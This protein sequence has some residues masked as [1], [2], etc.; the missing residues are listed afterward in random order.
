MG[1]YEK[2]LQDVLSGKKDGN[3]NFNELC[4]LLEKLG[5]KQER[6]TGS[7]HIFSYKNVAELVDIQP[8]KRDHSKAKAYQVKQ[9]KKF[10]IKYIEVL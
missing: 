9:V 1:K 3:I 10:I 4:Y 8:D 6:I 5:C 2:V 7:H